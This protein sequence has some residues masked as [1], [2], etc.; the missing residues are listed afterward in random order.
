MKG[1]SI[2]HVLSGHFADLLDFLASVLPI[3]LPKLFLS[4]SSVRRLI[5]HSQLS[6]SL[7]R[8]A[9]HQHKIAVETPQVLHISR[10]YIVLGRSKG[11]GH[12]FCKCQ[13]SE[14]N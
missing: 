4:G 5:K 13:G 12:I 8:Q 14:G 10:C 1:S 2:S 3:F 6:A 9:L 7:I 11:L